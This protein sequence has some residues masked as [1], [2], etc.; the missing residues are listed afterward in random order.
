MVT[1]RDREGVADERP[2]EFR[3]VE[4]VHHGFVR[5]APN[6]RYLQ[7]S[8]GASFYG[9]GLWYN[10]HFTGARPRRHHRGRTSTSSGGSA[11]TSSASTRRCSKRE[12]TGLGRY[13][14]ARVG[15]L[16][17]LVAW[18]EERDLHISWNLVFH[19]NI[20]EAVWGE[21]T[22][23]YR[24]NPYRTIAPARDFFAS[25]EAWKYQQKLYR[26]V[27]ARW[28]YSRAIFLWFVIDE[29]NGT[30][31]W[32]EGDRDAAHAWC[33]RMNDFFHEHDP[34]G[35]PTTGTQSGGVDQWWPEGYEIFDVAGREIYEAQG[36]PMPRGRQ[37]RPGERP[38]AAGAS[39]RNYAKQSRDLWSGFEKPAIIAETR[40]RP[41]LLRTRHAR[42]PGDV[43]QRAVGVARQRRRGHAV[44]VVVLA[45]HQRGRRHVADSR[46]RQL[47]PR[48]RLRRRDSGGPHAVEISAGDAW[49]MRSDAHDLRLGGEPRLGHRAG[50]DHA[51]RRSRR[52][53]RRAP[54]PHLARRLP[55]A[56]PR[57]RDRRHAHLRRP[58]AAPPTTAAPSTWATT[59][60]SRSR[61]AARIARLAPAGDAVVDYCLRLA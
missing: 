52:P 17:E 10:D 6:R 13:D 55:A 4:S 36:H 41:H 35:R 50:D 20:S 47:R 21:A 15:R 5:I 61:R 44:L 33:R 48:H 34:Y 2:G 37:A 59:W 31:G 39:Y 49:A 45:V 30:E 8:D 12:G 24:D 56:D 57:R 42:L 9:V 54:L 14:A 3:C 60:R 40:L 29:I 16:D 43:P 7:Y 38:P 11:S 27:I 22:P 28:G 19:A 46:L 23:E 25:D 26:Y 32:T 53:V 1:V 51:R 58:R 18:C